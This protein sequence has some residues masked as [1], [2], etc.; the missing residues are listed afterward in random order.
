MYTVLS[1]RKIYYIKKLIKDINKLPHNR[2]VYAWYYVNTGEIF[3]IGKGSNN[4][5]KEL[6]AHRNQ[7]F[8]NI[9]KKHL[10]K[11]EVDVK[12][13]Y[14]NL[15]EKESL[16]LER[17]LIHYYWSIG[18]CKA[19]LHEGGSGGWT[20]N[21]DNPE[22][23]RKISEFAKTRVGKLNSNYGGGHMSEETRKHLSEINK[24]KKLTPEHI[25]KLKYINHIR[26]RTK[27]ECEK[28]SKA[29]KGRKE[30]PEWILNN[31]KAHSKNNFFIIYKNQCVL[32]TYNKRI[33]YDYCKEHFNISR[34]IV[35]RIFTNF[36]TPNF[37]K[38]KQ[39]SQD[40]KIIITDKSVTTIPDECKGVD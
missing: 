18:Q 37:N 26:V 3:Y 9:I 1:I 38:F 14:E 36:W 21:Y 30:T 40:L 2:Y 29:I 23:S 35:Q 20:G 32:K 7:F 6:K 17:K 39:L 12:K 10:D 16:D 4:R 13:L 5:Y 8:K 34:T 15:G 22:R 31:V 19:N 33:V 27:E 11:H 25:E 24:G 28:L